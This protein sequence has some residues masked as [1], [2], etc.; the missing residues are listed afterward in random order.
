MSERQPRSKNGRAPHSTTGLASKSWT[1]TNGPA[2]SLRI[3]GFPGSRSDIEINSSG[4]ASAVLTQKRRVMS[5]SSA[6]GRFFDS[7][8]ARLQRHSAFRATARMVLHDLGMH[9]ANVLDRAGRYGHRWRLERHSA[10][11]T[12]AGPLCM[13]LGIHRTGVAARRGGRSRAIRRG[14]CRVHRAAAVSLVRKRLGLSSGRGRRIRRRAGQI[15]RR[16]GGEF[17]AAS[18][19]TKVVGDAV[20]N[21]RMPRGRR[22]DL[23]PAHRIGRH[24]LCLYVFGLMRLHMRRRLRRSF[25][26]ALTHDR[27]SANARLIPRVDRFHDRDHGSAGGSRG[28]PGCRAADAPGWSAARSRLHV[29]A[30]SRS[31][32]R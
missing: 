25:C 18:F 21:V 30:Q 27:I 8:D 9:R 1:H 24:R 23:H 12:R 7:G 4:T 19:A 22:I 11:R 6:I 17:R 26:S 29:R 5:A 15:L 31:K 10:F 32:C 13:H 2:P 20:V 14:G 28:W 3:S 16:R